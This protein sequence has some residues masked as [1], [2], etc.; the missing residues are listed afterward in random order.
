M[1]ACHKGVSQTLAIPD[2]VALLGDHVHEGPGASIEP[3]DTL[4]DAKRE[5]TSISCNGLIAHC[6]VGVYLSPGDEMKNRW[7]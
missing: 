4:K 7:R 6:V 1:G 2:Q 5:V 3:S